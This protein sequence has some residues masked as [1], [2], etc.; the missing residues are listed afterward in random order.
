M[1]LTFIWLLVFSPVFG[2][3]RCINGDCPFTEID[4]TQCCK[5]GRFISDE[6]ARMCNCSIETSYNADMAHAEKKDFPH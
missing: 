1:K 5:A 3:D 6:C 4:C 2:R